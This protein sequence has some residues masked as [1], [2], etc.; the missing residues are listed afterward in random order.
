MIKNIVKV[1]FRNPLRNK[2]FSIINISGL[3]IGM[4][5]AI[6]ILLRMYNEINYDN[7]LPVLL[8]L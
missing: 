3:A 8:I 7:F 1:A 4:A 2:A 6:I 5:S